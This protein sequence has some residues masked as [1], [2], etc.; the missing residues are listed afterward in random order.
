MLSW[1]NLIKLFRREKKRSST[2]T[3]QKPARSAHYHRVMNELN[4]ASD[5]I[6]AYLG[7]PENAG[8][9]N[10]LL[11][12]TQEFGNY[13]T[14]QA[15]IKKMNL[16]IS[17]GPNF[18]DAMQYAIS[19]IRKDEKDQPTS[20]ATG[21]TPRFDVVLTDA[22]TSSLRIIKMVKDIAKI[23]LKKARDLVEHVPSTILTGADKDDAELVQEILQDAG[24]TV[25]LVTV[26]PKD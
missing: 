23:D 10:S 18:Y 1:T 16:S 19:R 7:Q 25:E 5:Q 15:L 14:G 22:G 6:Y 3:R 8:L 2:A 21:P 11:N 24:A 12:G 4:Q 17:F 26:E 13:T 9:K 20:Q